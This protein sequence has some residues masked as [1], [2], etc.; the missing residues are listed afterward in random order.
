MRGMA[1]TN[2]MLERRRAAD[3]TPQQNTMGLNLANVVWPEDIK[4]RRILAEQSLQYA[5]SSDTV[6]ILL[7]KDMSPLE[8][9]LMCTEKGMAPSAVKV[10]LNET[11]VR[12]CIDD[13][14]EGLGKTAPA[15]HSAAERSCP[16]VVALLLQAGADPRND[17]GGSEWR[18]GVNALWIAC[19]HGRLQTARLLV[20]AGADVEAPKVRPGRFRPAHIAAQQGHVE[21]LVILFAAGA[22]PNSR[23]AEDLTPMH[24]ACAH[25]RSAAIAALARHGSDIYA[26]FG[27]TQYQKRFGDLGEKLKLTAE[28]TEERRAAVMMAVP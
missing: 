22:N 17:S 5:A 24:M 4:G 15:I 2:N 7:D 13:Y 10:L 26:E 21:V 11:D 18:D 6:R 16:A 8:L 19:E 12:S 28:E 25:C 14:V 9:L 23:M 3:T 20:A 1:A 27:D